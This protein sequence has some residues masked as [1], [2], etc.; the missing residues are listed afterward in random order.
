MALQKMIP[1]TQDPQWYKDAVI[2]EVPV[3]SFCDSNGDGIGD[4][5]GLLHKLDYLERLGVTALWLL[6]FYPSP[7]KDDGYDIAEYFSVHKD[8][9]QLQDFKAFLREAH[10]RGLKV[11]TELVINHT[12]SDHLW[13]KK[14]RQAEPGSYWRDF[15]V[16]SDTPNRYEDARIIFKDFEQSNWTWDP[17]AGAYYWHR[18]YSHQPDLNFDNPEVQKAVFEALDF[19][20]DMGVDGLRL[21]A[22]PYL[23]ERE[24]TNCENL[25]ETHAFL[26]KLRAHV[27]ARHR[28]KMLLAEANQWPEDAVAYFGDGDECH[29]SFH[30]P[31]MPR[32]FMSLWMEDRFPLID[33]IEQT[34]EIPA[35][36]QWALF[37]RNH[38]ELTLEM[39][40]DEER[41]Y[42][43]R[44]YASDPRARI[45]LGIRRRLAPLMHNNRRKLELLTLLLLSLPGTPVLYYGDEIG[46]GDNFFLG[47]RNGVR[48]PMQWTPD[49]NAGFSTANPQQ[50][51]LPVIHDPE[52]HFQSINVENQEK[53]PSS[54]LWWMR[55][56]IAMR[57]RFRAF[58]RGAIDFLL[59]DNEKV[60]T[61]IRSYGEEHILVVVNLSRFSQSV[62]LDLSE[63]AG[64]VPEEL[65]SGNRFP[66][67]GEDPYPLT[68]GFND[69]FWFVL[70]EPQSRLQT[71][72]GPPRLE[73]DTDWKH[74]LHGTFREYLEMEVLP[75]FLR[76]SRWFGSKAKTMRHLQV[77][78][79]V[80]MGH[81]GEKTH[82]LVVR[83]D[84][85]EGGMEHYLLPLSYTDRAE[86]ESLL[87]EHPQAVIA[88]LELQDSS[89]VL[90]DGLF[91]ASFRTVLLEMILGQ[92][93]K[94][95]PGGEV[96]GVRG[97][98]LKSLIKDG[99]HIP[100]SRVLAAEQSNSSILYG[101]SVILK[102]YR[103]L[104][105]G[106]NPDAEITRHL[107]RLRHGPKVPG[108]AGLLEYR[109]E[110]Q[111]PVTLGL[112]QQ[113]VPSRGDA[114]TFV[115]SEL[116]SFWDRVARDET[117]WQGP[118]PG[119]LPRAGNAAMPEELLDR[120]GQ[121]FLDKIE[122]LGRRTGELH[123]ALTDSDP[124]SPFAPEPFSKLYQRSLY[125]SVRYQVRKTLHSVRRHLD[126]LP[127][128]IRPQAEALLVNEHLVLERLG[129]LTAHRVEAQKIRIH[130]DYHLGQVLYT[131]EDFWIIDFEG[132]PARP[133]SERRLKRSP[134]R[135]VAGM[136]RSFDYA[137]HTS[138]SRQESGVTSA[139][140]RSWTAPWYAAVCRT[141]LRG[142]L[143]QVEDAAFVP[144]DP[145]DIWRLLEGFLIEKAVYEVG[146]EANNRPHWIWL[147][148]GGLLRLLGKEPDVDS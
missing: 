43:Y 25:P 47:D 23:Y 15:Y 21:D 44:V 10:Q 3:K 132:E 111:E 54:L 133:L 60:L 95:G 103:R 65:F 51:Y 140:G 57:R 130:G 52:Y 131:G 148:L 19:W 138:L 66:E 145:E 11:I 8:Y 74:L 97:R 122:L 35:G 139:V 24:G 38:D 55:R 113:Y 14:S 119:W 34:P 41:D 141:Y 72:Q 114:W 117:R 85:T 49:R 28:N 106:T 22:I 92:R 6:P 37:L 45:N 36:C 9:G 30:F 116:D 129:G 1:V 31:I 27:D 86:A 64:R 108:F 62:R 135:D 20:L 56:V 146:Y 142:Y 127:E 33:M 17:V 125:Q 7:L 83:V 63:Y 128:A 18:F 46:M 126:E 68:L 90:Y 102:L 40:S 99:H 143:D 50:L 89:G 94:S 75:R 61:F 53:N 12:S 48:T 136:L 73:M 84:Y 79:D 77:V 101:Q 123:R 29:M 71:P 13:F 91:S 100:A 39:V 98:C 5:R 82:L 134:L 115:L 81:N 107:G 118:E 124:E 96:H 58:S 69:Y 121:E 4:F 76:Q 70:R 144:R 88:Y 110:D 42:M 105:Q 26:K 87:Q 16:W 59:P 137:V 80:N 32:I 78:E 120:V 112:A 104:E 2:Y 67:I 93:K 109:R 147:P